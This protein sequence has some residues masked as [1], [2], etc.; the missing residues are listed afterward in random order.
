MIAETVKKREARI[1]RRNRSKWDWAGSVMLWV[2]ER[3]N[4]TGRMAARHYQRI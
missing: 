4:R 2:R 3:G 1:G